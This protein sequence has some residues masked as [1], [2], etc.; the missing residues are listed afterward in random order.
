LNDPFGTVQPG[1]HISYTISYANVGGVPLS[2]IVI[3]DTV[4][5]NTVLD[6]GSIH[7][8]ATVVGDLIRWE[9]PPLAP[10]AGSQVGFTVVVSTTT[11]IAPRA[12]S[13]GLAVGDTANVPRV[14]AVN[15]PP[16][17]Q[18]CNVAWV[19]AT[20]TNRWVPSN[21]AFNPSLRLYLPLVM[22]Q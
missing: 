15:C 6:P 19:Y 12:A 20:Q 8:P 11:T 7:P 17:A 18:V 21:P 13:F 4:P 3:T 5:T 10:G 16:S 9:V 1:E 14:P 2:G 22:K